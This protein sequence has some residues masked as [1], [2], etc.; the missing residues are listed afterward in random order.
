MQYSSF[1]GSLSGWVVAVMCW[2]DA[3][4]TRWHL[5]EDWTSKS[6]MS[7]PGVVIPSGGHSAQM[8]T[9]GTSAVYFLFSY[10]LFFFFFL[11]WKII[12]HGTDHESN[13]LCGE[14]PLKNI[15]ISLFS[16]MYK[17]HYFFWAGFPSLLAVLEETSKRALKWLL[18]EGIDFSSMRWCLAP[19]QFDAIS[20]FSICNTKPCVFCV[21]PHLLGVALLPSAVH[22]WTQFC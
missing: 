1:A 5:T 2:E 20:T 4:V 6:L 14:I 7:K 16:C 15:W 3:P 10:G 17:L 11:Y 8:T 9:R 19:I 12:F 13:N 22:S 18:H 21:G